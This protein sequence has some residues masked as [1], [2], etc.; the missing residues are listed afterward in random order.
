MQ[1]CAIS[2][3]HATSKTFGV[4]VLETV[5][6]WSALAVAS[7]SSVSVIEIE[8]ARAPS[9]ASLAAL[10]NSTRKLFEPTA[11]AVS[12]PAP[13]MSEELASEGVRTTAC[14]S[15]ERGENVSWAARTKTQNRE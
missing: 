15:K 14:K 8:S 6:D 3:R 9:T 7:F 2:E 10:R 4:A 13:L 5:K 12:T 1:R 11:L